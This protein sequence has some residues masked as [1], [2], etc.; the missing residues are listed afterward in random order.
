MPAI[1]SSGDLE[2]FKEF[3]NV[4]GKKVLAYH[5]D[6]DGVTASAILLKYF[7]NFETLSRKGPKTD[8][9]FIKTMVKK[10]PLLIVFLDLPMDQEKDAIKKLEARLPSCRFIIIDHHIIENDMNSKNI[11]H[12][13]PRFKL[14]E[15]YIPAS[16]IMYRLFFSLNKSG[17]SL[18]NRTFDDIKKYIWIALLGVIGDHAYDNCKDLMLES[19]EYSESNL[20]EIANMLSSATTKFKDYK[21]ITTVLSKLLDAKDLKDIES[22]KT[23]KEWSNDVDKEFKKVIEM[24]ETKKE[25]QGKVIIYELKTE[26]GLS[27]MVSGYLSERYP[28]RVILI[29]KGANGMWKI[30]L[31]YQKGDINLGETV[32]SCLSEGDSGGGHEKAAGGLIKDIEDFKK[33]FLEQINQQQ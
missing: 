33:R 14:K 8:D 6:L 29:Y 9:A 5:K 19:E 21:G 11:L 13:N 3:M 10:D 23:L 25:D 16:Y 7:P 12:I 20:R 15:A 2:R 24:F 31:R 26:Y 28:D 17:L 32:K 30:S 1:F 27:A 18:G 22:D 4:E